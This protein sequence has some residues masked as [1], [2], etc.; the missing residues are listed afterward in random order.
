MAG[1]VTRT[2]DETCPVDKH[3]APPPP[4]PDVAETGV[5]SDAARRRSDLLLLQRAIREGWD[6]PDAAFRALPAEVIR[7]IFE[8]G[9][10]VRDRLRAVECVL[11]MHRQ[12]LGHPLVDAL[13]RQIEP[14]TTNEDS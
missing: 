12:N 10:N 11:S 7:V 6:I 1:R 4:A 3:S 2:T 13:V 9:V 14:E 5:L 8:R